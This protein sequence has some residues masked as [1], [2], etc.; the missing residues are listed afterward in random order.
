MEK[1]KAHTPSE[2]EK[3][4]R[5]ESKLRTCERWKSLRKQHVYCVVFSGGLNFHYFVQYMAG[6][7]AW[8]AWQSYI[9]VQNIAD[10]PFSLLAFIDDFQSSAGPWRFFS[11]MKVRVNG[12]W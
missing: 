9:L 5:K 6:Y 10:F 1:E 4:G 8:Q 11:K 3:T 12:K 2:G 7:L